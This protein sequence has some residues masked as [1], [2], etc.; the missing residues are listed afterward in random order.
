[1]KKNA[2]EEHFTTPDLSTYAHGP[3]SG[4]DR[5]NFRRFEKL[6]LEFDSM[7][8]AAMD[9]AGI[10]LAALSVTTPGVQVEQDVCTAVKRAREANDFLAREIAMHPTRDA[11]FAHL[12]E[13]APISEAT[14]AKI[15]HGT[16]A[17]LLHL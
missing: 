3:G 10:E 2:L 13:S 4:M 14:R 17:R 15:C 16:A 6:L 9:Q 12:I 8:L 11:G 1:M 7:R 5:D